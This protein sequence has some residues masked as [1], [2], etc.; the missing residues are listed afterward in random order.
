[1][2]KRRRLALGLT[3]AAVLLLAG[4]IYVANIR[5]EAAFTVTPSSG[6]TPL[7]VLFDASTST[8]PDGTIVTFLWDF[9]D[10]QTASLV[11]PTTLHTYTVQSVSQVFTSVLK[12]VD[13]LGGE[14]TAVRN[15]TVNP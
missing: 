11:V 1:M 5:P 4:C 7:V 13:D 8:D 9:G 14:D 6:T 2:K 10:G 15:I 3:G 12:V